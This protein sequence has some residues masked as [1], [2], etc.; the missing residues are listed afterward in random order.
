MWELA[1]NYGTRDIS[2]WLPPSILTTPSLIMQLVLPL[3]REVKALPFSYHSSRFG[4]ALL[5]KLDVISWC[6]TDE[7]F[8]FDVVVHWVQRFQQEIAWTSSQHWLILHG[9]VYTKLIFS[10]RLPDWNLETDGVGKKQFWSDF[11]Y[12]NFVIGVGDK[13]YGVNGPPVD[14]TP[15]FVQV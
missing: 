15:Q 8:L 4:R 9:S 5:L 14:C 13:I 3:W 7:P 6:I 10:R 11:H 1:L 2:V 12:N